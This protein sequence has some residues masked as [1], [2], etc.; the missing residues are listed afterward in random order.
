MDNNE[1]LTGSI[2]VNWNNDLPLA[3][4]NVPEMTATLRR[5]D[6]QELSMGKYYFT[7]LPANFSKGF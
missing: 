1:K 3:K 7:I 2:K 4:S 5:E 6:G